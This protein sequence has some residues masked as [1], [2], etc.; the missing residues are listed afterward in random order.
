VHCL[1]GPLLLVA[2]PTLATIVAPDESFHRAMLWIV[3]PSAVLAFA[4]GCR[5]HRDLLTG[6][7]GGAGL[8]LFVLA[9]TWLH[10]L[11]GEGGERIVTLASAGMLGAAHVRNFRRCRQASCELGCHH[12]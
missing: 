7:L 1:L 3:I 11:I 8:V 4:I 10:D 5:R 6:V 2:G 9:V 12:D